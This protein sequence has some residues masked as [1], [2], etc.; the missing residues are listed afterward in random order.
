MNVRINL[1][2]LAFPR[3]FCVYNINVLIGQFAYTNVSSRQHGVRE[4]HY[5]THHS[6]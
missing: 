4:H 2:S 5:I 1:I 3:V 6:R